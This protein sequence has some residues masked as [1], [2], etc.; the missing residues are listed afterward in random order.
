MSETRKTQ[1]HSKWNGKITVNNNFKLTYKNANMFLNMNTIPGDEKR[2]NAEHVNYL[3]ECYQ[4]GLF[5]PHMVCLCDVLVGKIRYRTNGYHTCKMYFDLGVDTPSMTVRRITIQTK[6]LDE[7]R[8]VYQQFDYYGS[9]RTFAQM[10]NVGL[11]TREDMKGHTKSV[12]SLVAAAYSTLFKLREMKNDKS[13]IHKLTGGLW[14]VRGQHRVDLLM[15]KYGEEQC[16]GALDFLLSIAERRYIGKKL[17]VTRGTMAAVMITY[18]DNPEKAIEFWNGLLSQN[19]N[20]EWDARKP[21]RDWLL[22]HKTAG[23]K[24]G[25]T[26]MISRCFSHWKA[27]LSGRE[28][29]QMMPYRDPQKKNKKRSK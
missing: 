14:R 6:T 23:M 1:Y 13:Q 27:W 24:R 5:I 15:N 9:A 8:E 7:A 11:A 19:Y 28:T 10:L 2:Q 29:K 17:V 25:E 16:E 26:E 4:K 12:W 3:K 20:S 18:E 21:L 22:D